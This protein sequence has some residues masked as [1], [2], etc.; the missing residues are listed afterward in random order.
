M[1]GKGGEIAGDQNTT[2]E[3]GPVHSKVQNDT[4][5]C[6]SYLWEKV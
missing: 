5:V 1:G 6:I 2:G 3:L 4:H